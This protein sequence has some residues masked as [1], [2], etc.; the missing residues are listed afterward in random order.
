MYQKSRIALATLSTILFPLS[1]YYLSPALSI[2]G[3]AEGILTGSLIIFIMMFLTS[4][5]IGRVF[6]SWL[7]PTAMIQ[8]LLINARSRR[9]NVKKISW[10]KYVIWAPWIITILFMFKRSGGIHTIDFFYQTEMGVSLTRLVDT[11]I[12]G[13]IVL[14]IYI[15]SMLV[16]RR[17]TCHTICWMAPFMI[18]GKKL[19][20]KIKA[21]S[22]RLKREPSKCISCKKCTQVCPMSLEVED[23]AKKLEVSDHNCILCGKC[24][25]ICPKNVLKVA[26]GKGEN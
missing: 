4:V 5:F 24:V 12:Y 17:A 6:C 25:D 16:G 2:M 3:P 26:I 1:F 20:A 8:D 21:P 13:G 23:L 11:F 15:L 19:G 22:L 10:I 7:C 18:L 14:L 9:V